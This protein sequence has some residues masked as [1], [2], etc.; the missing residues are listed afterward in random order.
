M[1][2]PILGMARV[3]WNAIRFSTMRFCGK[4]IIS[5]G[6][7]TSRIG[8]EY[9]VSKNGYVLLGYHFSALN[10][11]RLLITGGR[12]RIGN[13]VGLNTNCIIACRE[14][15][16]IGDNVEIGPNVCIYDHDH[17]IYIEGGLKARRFLT[18]PVIIGDGT[19][20]GANVVIL[21]GTLIG[22]NCIIGAGSVVKGIVPDNAIFIQKR[23]NT[24]LIQDKI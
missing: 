11:C 3:T 4:N 20:I 2:D 8:N 5:K 16:I 7:C 19:W 14:E 17:D 18:E 9:R 12:L 1:I 10:R 22:K 24:I 15:V 13:N 23:E 6:R 21:K